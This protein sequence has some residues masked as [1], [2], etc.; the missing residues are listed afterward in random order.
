MLSYAKFKDVDCEF[1][2]N[3]L[4]KHC[5]ILGCTTKVKKVTT[6][7][8]STTVRWAT[9]SL[10]LQLPT[11]ERRKR[12][13]QSPYLQ[14]DVGAGEEEFP[15]VQVDAGVIVNGEGDGLLIVLYFMDFIDK[16]RGRQ[17]GA[18]SSLTSLQP[19]T[20]KRKHQSLPIKC[21]YGTLYI[22]SMILQ[23]CF[24]LYL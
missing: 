15:Y 12:K 20:R 6:E 24:F 23:L 2:F 10:P 3:R 8:G 5:Q 18:L 14:C 7:E 22:Q 21:T 17:T 9:L 16:K 4:Y 11:Q 1:C 13:R 19:R